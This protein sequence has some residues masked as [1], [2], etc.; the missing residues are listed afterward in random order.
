MEQIELKANL[1]TEKGKQQVKKLR[2]KGFVPAVVYHKGEETV[3]VSVVGK[4]ISRIIHGAAGE[5]TLINLKIEDGKKPRARAVL[6]KEVQ[7]GPVKRDLLH[8]DFNEISLSEKVTVEVE[9]IPNGDPMGVKLEGGMLDHPLRM[10]K[11]QCLPADIPKHVDVDVSGLRLGGAIY[12]KDLRLPETLKVITDADALLF[13]VR[14]LA[15][16][17]EEAAAEAPEIEVIREKKE[18]EPKAAEK[19]KEEARTEKK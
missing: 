15:E 17:P 2:G 11:I 5:N 12:V 19:A 10:I 8:L 4:E 16:K 3:C 1:R 18:E 9:V 13:Q 6:V 14:L 7:Y